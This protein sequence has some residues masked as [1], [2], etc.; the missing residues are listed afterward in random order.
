MAVDQ[1]AARGVDRQAF[2]D[3]YRRN[4]ARSKMLFDLVSPDA[5][6]SRPIPLR[7]PIVFYEGHLP[8]F[9]VNT[10]LKKGLARPGIHFRC[11]LVP[12]FLMKIFSRR[13]E[14]MR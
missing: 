11:S 3:W 14:V 6:Y 8:A 5:Y 4:R 7:H 10:L 13:D 9:S 1:A 2:I 12:G